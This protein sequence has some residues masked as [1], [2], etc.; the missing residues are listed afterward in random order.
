MQK[1]EK[2]SSEMYYT[3]CTELKHF[4]YVNEKLE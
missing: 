1:Q 2:R 4:K 3:V